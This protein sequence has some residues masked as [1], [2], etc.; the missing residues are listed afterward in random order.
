MKGTP[1]LHIKVAPAGATVRV[2]FKGTL[3]A[4]SRDAL[5]LKEGSYPTVYYFP[6]K[7]VKMER[8]VRSSHKTHCPFKGDA[9]YYSLKDGPEN[10]VWSYEQP[11]DEMAAIKERLAFYPDKVEIKPS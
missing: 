2:T 1:A 3:I 6:R 10:A 5:A 8:L 4:E 11:F 7:D 9:S